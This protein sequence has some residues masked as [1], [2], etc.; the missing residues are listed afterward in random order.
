[1]L[2][3]SCAWNLKPAGNLRVILLLPAPN[4]SM[5]EAETVCAHAEHWEST[6]T[7]RIREKECLLDT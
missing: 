2:R 7:A 1:M 3:F 5:L 6:W 4:F